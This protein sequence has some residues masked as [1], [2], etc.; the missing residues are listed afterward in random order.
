M[1]AAM[2][3]QLR[4]HFTGGIT[5]AAEF[6]LPL[7]P[8]SVLV[9]FG[10]SGSGK[11]TVLRCLAGL[12]WPDWGCIRFGATTWLDTEARVRVPA[13]GRSVGYMFQDYALFPT[14]SVTGNIA[15]GLGGLPTS[16]RRRRVEDLV[17]VLQLQGLERL[18]PAALSGGQ[19][20]RV[21]LARA[22]ARRPSL[23]LLDEPLSA[24][25]LP[26]R[27]AV[28]ADLRHVLREQKIPSIVVT[29][30]WEEALAL[31]DLMVVMHEGQILQSGPPQE[32]FNK[33]QNAEV[34]KI[35]GMET[36]IPGCVLAA[37]NGMVTVQAGERTLVALG[38]SPPGSEVF[39]CIRAEDVVLEAPSHGTSSARNRLVGVVRAVMP[40]GALVRVTVDCGPT[41]SAV[42][43]RAA[44]EDL[45]L[46]PGAPVVAA[47]KAGAVHLIRREGTG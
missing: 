12:E 2:T 37:G 32:V 40:F 25:D 36:V 28:R 1:A 42:V 11:T 43:T 38:E 5:I 45:R 22:L 6:S 44:F 3:V 8:P 17:A 35:V 7:D 47:I 21:A 29:H 31:G 18:K 30:E 13:Q 14:Y 26:T 16:E 27:V 10:P 24:L 23:L 39:A 9:L 19:Q 15:F 46:H 4:K 33:P 20:Q 41:L 34:A